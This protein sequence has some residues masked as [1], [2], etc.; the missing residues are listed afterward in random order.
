[1]LAPNVPPAPTLSTWLLLLLYALLLVVAVLLVAQIV[2]PFLP[3]PDVGDRRDA[4]LAKDEDARR[5]ALRK[6]NEGAGR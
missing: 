3:P 5:R 4:D 1:M 2:R 6:A